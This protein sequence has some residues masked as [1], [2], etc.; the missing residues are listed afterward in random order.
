M[1][2]RKLAKR[3]HKLATLEGDEKEET[4]MY[5]VAL[6]LE[7]GKDGLSRNLIGKALSE[8]WL[9]SAQG[10]VIADRLRTRLH[11]VAAYI[12]AGKT[13]IEEEQEEET[14]QLMSAPETE[15]EKVEEDITEE[16]KESLTTE[17]ITPVTTE[18][19]QPKKK[20]GRPRTRPL[21]DPNAP[22]IPKRPRGR[23][24]KNA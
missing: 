11:K 23:P 1:T 24:R 5:A 18:D 14:E 15:T 3:L 4:A 17:V 21:P 7:T 9:K 6:L 13:E 19:S 16:V 8:L 10:H 2:D 20:R 12:K 22:V